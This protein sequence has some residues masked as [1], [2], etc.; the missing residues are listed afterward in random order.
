ME[1]EKKPIVTILTY[2]CAHNISDSELMAGVLE[3]SGFIVKGLRDNEC[4]D[5]DSNDDDVDCYVINTCTVKNPTQQKFEH[6]LSTIKKP[7]V[8]CGCIPQS[9]VGA[10]WLKNYSV[11]GVTQ[12]S[13]IAIAVEETLKGNV[14]KF[15]KR[16]KNPRH[17]LPHVRKNDLVGIVPIL[18][19][20]LGE[21]TYCK[22][23]LARGNLYSYS[24]GAI[25]NEI[26]HHVEEGCKE[27][28]LVSE[29]NGAYGLDIDSSLPQLLKQII[30]INFDDVDKNNFKVRVGMLNPDFAYKYRFELPK[31]MTNKRFYNF[32]HIPIQCGSNKVLKDMKREYTI[33]EAI[34]AIDEL[35][36]EN[37][38]ML[39]M[40]D[41]ICGFPTESTSDFEETVTVI[42]KVKF[43]LINISKMY[44]R[45]NT[46]AQKLKPLPTK[47]VKRRSRIITELFYEVA[48][49]ESW[50]NWEGEV[51]FSSIGKNGILIGKNFAYKQVLVKGDSSLIGQTRI[52]K[53][54]EVTRDD[55]RGELVERF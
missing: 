13:K 44:V 22:T 3:K 30:D 25:I 37:P 10:K 46:P 11:I 31:I 2:G 8:L 35:R 6:V 49:N 52:V 27:I 15:L 18:E 38:Q 40:T 20:C 5:F 19:G 4:S 33:E 29:D 21:C 42:K 51:F 26:K 53:I 14:V 55:L 12:L 24:P 32:L 36:K 28:W 1:R 47:E 45:P 34:E 41:I 50:K 48:T 17:N 54:N 7:V 16:E 43:D 23:K 39:V 9:E